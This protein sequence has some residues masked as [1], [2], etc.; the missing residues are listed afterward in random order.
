MIIYNQTIKVSPSIDTAWLA[1]L[2][3][4]HLPAIMATQCFE[5]YQLVRLLDTDDADGA[6]Y[7][8]QYYAATRANYEAFGTQFEPLLSR[9]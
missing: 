9:E 4:I 5:R 7:A 6:T 1:W 8:V 3:Q 2:Q